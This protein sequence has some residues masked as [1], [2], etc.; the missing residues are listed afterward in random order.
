MKKQFLRLALF[1]LALSLPVS[2][3]RNNQALVPMAAPVQEETTQEAEAMEEIY[4]AVPGRL[5]PTSANAWVGDVM[6][7]GDGDE[8][9]LYY[10]YDTDHNGPLYHPIHLFTTTNFYE[11]RDEG[12]AV[13]CGPDL[14]APD[15]AIGTG[16][17]LKARE[18]LYHCFYTGHNDTAPDKGRDKEC[19]MHAVSEDGLSWKKVPEDTFYAPEQYSGD[20][21]RD[22]FVFWNEEAE[23]YWLLIAT[24]DDKLGGIVARY[25]SDDLSTWTLMEPLYAPGRQYMLECPDLFKMGEKYY[26]FY[27]WDCVTYYA[28]A[29]SIDGPFV[30]ADDPVL[31]STGFSY[32]AAKTAELNGSR[33]LC[34]WIGRKQEPKD[35]GAYDWAGTMM[36]HELVLKDDGTLGIR[37]PHTLA[38]YFTEEKAVAAVDLSGDCQ[39]TEHGFRL[40]AETKKDLSVVNLG[41][42]QPVFQLECTVR[43]TDEG[44]AGFC[45]GQG[46]NYGNYVGLVIDAKNNALHYEGSILSRMAFVDPLIKTD[47]EIQPGIDYHIRMI[48]ENEICTVYIDQAKVLCTRVYKAM[49]GGNLGLFAVKTGVEFRDI[50]LMVP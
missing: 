28:V 37:E 24:R 2:G 5:F 13:K 29:D 44:Y 6:P 23:C 39:V 27:S 31:A 12:L 38:E 14:D 40:T 19:V 45:F 49:D 42:R 4:Q 18:G 50:S 36:I 26:L 16:S 11:Y 25:R 41:M 7:M 10:L 17:V 48:M 47:I 43:F 21:F 3:S 46:D 35:A 33:Y 32:Y 22:P 1:L 20:D 15:S 30:Q 8:L 9:K 34:G